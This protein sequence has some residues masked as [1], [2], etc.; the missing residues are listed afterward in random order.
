ML[1][2]PVCG[3]ALQ[4]TE[5]TLRCENNHSF[6]MAKEGYVNLLRSNKNGDLIGDDKQ[7]ARSRRDF[8]NKGYYAPLKDEL[9]HIFAD[10]Q[11]AVLDICK[12]R[13]VEQL[14]GITQL[15]WVKIHSYRSM[16]SISPVRWCALLP[17]GAMEHTSLPTWHPYL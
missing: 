14:K 7:S 8:L 11:G 16:A 9:C 5:R 4:R 12:F 10:K 13:F 15:L 1:I 17:S 2:C 6:D 3:Q